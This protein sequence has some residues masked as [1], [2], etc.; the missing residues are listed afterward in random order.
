MRASLGETWK[1]DAIDLNLEFQKL[2]VSNQKQRDATDQR[3]ARKLRRKSMDEKSCGSVLS[4]R[5][6]FAKDANKR[7]KV[8]ADE[9]RKKKQEKAKTMRKNLE[10]ESTEEI[11]PLQKSIPTKIGLLKDLNLKK[12]SGIDPIHFYEGYLVGYKL[13]RDFNAIIAP[14]L[15]DTPRSNSVSP[16]TD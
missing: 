5:S 16:R 8:L 7:A 15:N 11:L 10:T 3:T 4:D 6:Y 2:V 9:N 1:S 12:L 13:R 14:G